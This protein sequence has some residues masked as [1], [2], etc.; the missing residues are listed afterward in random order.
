MRRIRS[1]LTE[2][3]AHGASANRSIAR[4]R[5]S[6]Y[7]RISRRLSARIV[8]S[9]WHT[10][11]GGSPPW[12]LP[13]LIEPRVGWK[14]IPSSRAAWISASMKRSWPCGNR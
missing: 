8:S 6:W 4:G 1:S 2:N 12:L 5:G 11:S 7:S 14:R 10:T 3:G 9:S 13:R